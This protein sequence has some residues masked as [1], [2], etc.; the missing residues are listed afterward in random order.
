MSAADYHRQGADAIK[1]DRVR[2]AEIEHLLAK[3]FE[4]WAELDAKAT[5]S[6]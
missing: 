2:A 6:A 3:K 5:A 4:R 1:S